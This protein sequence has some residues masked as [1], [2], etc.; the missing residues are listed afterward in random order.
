MSSIVALHGFT[1]TPSS[2][3]PL[4]EYFGSA[5][6]LT[7]VS[8]GHGVPAQ[9]SEVASFEAEV[10]RL[11]R[12]ARDNSEGPVLVGYS[13]GGRLALG[14]ALQFAAS[15]RG[16]VLISASA[17]L[18]SEAARAERRANDARWIA[19]LEEHG[20]EAFADRWQAQP[21]FAT[22]L[23]LSQSLIE[24][25]RHRRLSHTARGLAHSLR[26]TG[27]A[28]MPN[29]WPRLSE[30]TLPV[31]LLAGARDPKF[32]ASARRMASQ[33]P[34]AVVTEVP[35]VGHNLLLERPNAVIR[36]IEKGLLS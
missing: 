18:E 22:Q 15:F 11:A 16:L 31:T 2:F 5:N 23:E 32:C 8:T 12:L 20:V 19:L 33:I 34:G 14:I 9:G 10:S 7:P 21:L 1:G 35:G 3:A 6:L 28:E 30:I 13:L 36:A 4:A 27:L 17:G 24:A 25:E 29:Y 26:V